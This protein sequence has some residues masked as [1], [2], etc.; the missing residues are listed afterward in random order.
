MICNWTFCLL[1]F[2][3][4]TENMPQTYGTNSCTE[5][6][7]ANFFFL[8]MISLFWTWFPFSEHDSFFLSLFSRLKCAI[9]KPWK[10]I[11]FSQMISAQS[12]AFFHIFLTAFT[13]CAT[14]LYKHACI[15]ASPIE[16]VRWTFR[17]NNLMINK[18]GELKKKYLETFKNATKHR[19]ADADSFEITFSPFKFGGVQC[20]CV[21]FI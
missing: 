15:H 3:V 13:I 8:N 7:R 16:K 19:V 9:F 4:Y 17:K 12:H 1:N 21:R 2:A 14:K 6:L 11:Q 18:Y 10:Y 20:A 5:D